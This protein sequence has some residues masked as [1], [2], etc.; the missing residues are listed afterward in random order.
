M[1]VQNLPTYA[2]KYVNVTYR[3][4]QGQ[5]VSLDGTVEKANALAI[6]LKVKGKGSLLLDILDIETMTEVDP[7]TKMPRIK[8]RAMAPIN[9]DQVRQ[10]LADRHGVPVAEIPLNPKNAMLMHSGINHE[11]LGHV[12]RAD[13]ETVA[14]R[15]EIISQ[16][17]DDCEHAGIECDSAECACQC[18]DC[19][20]GGDMTDED[21]DEEEIGG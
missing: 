6:L 18:N 11:G 10:H 17:D 7:P 20:P 14:K 9:E 8:V 1:T 5:Q 16:T 3:D 15:A 2:G 21:Q 4:E 12:H 13:I 19:A